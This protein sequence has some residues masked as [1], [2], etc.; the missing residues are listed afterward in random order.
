MNQIMVLDATRAPYPIMT[1]T[2]EER[3]SER[4]ATYFLILL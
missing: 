4:N 3:Q 2:L 1:S